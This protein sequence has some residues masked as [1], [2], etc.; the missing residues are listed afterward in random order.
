VQVGHA[1]A[2]G[3]KCFGEGRDSEL[4]VCITLGTGIGCGIVY[5]NAIFRGAL[6]T[7]GEVGH[8]PAVTNGRTCACGRSGCMETYASGTGIARSAMEHP[9]FAGRA[10]TSEKVFALAQEG[11]Q[12]ALSILYGAVEVLG[13]A[14]TTVINTLSPDMLIFSGGMSEQRELFVEPLIRYLRSHGYGLAVGEKLKIGISSLGN[15]APMFG[16]AMLDKAL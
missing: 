7:A 2:W 14:L 10:M 16:A 13:Q 4:L 9:A 1:A 15:D 12:D 11:N 8:I 3:E 5:K 6:Y